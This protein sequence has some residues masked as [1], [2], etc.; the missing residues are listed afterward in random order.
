MKGSG[1]LKAI[2]QEREGGRVRRKKGFFSPPAQPAPCKEKVLKKGIRR[3]ASASFTSQKGNCQEGK[4]GKKSTRKNRKE[5][6]IFLDATR[7]RKEVVGCSQKRKKR[8]RWRSLQA[9]EN[10]WDCAREAPGKRRKPDS[11]ATMKGNGNHP[12]RRNSNCSSVR[13]TAHLRLPAGKL[14]GENPVGYRSP[15]RREK[16]RVRRSRARRRGIYRP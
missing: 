15:T 9:V 11:L 3:G 16:L 7:S 5:R 8:G 2:W 1:G 14:R 12:R 10:R 6:G 4:R 13:C